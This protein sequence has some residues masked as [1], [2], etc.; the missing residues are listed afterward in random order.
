MW[1][2]DDFAEQLCIHPIHLSNTIKN[3]TGISACG[4]LQLEIAR[5]ARKLVANLSNP[6]QDI[7]FLLDFEPSQFTKWY[8]RVVGLTPK[9][10]RTQIK[11]GTTT[12]ILNTSLLE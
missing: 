4:I 2:I 1:D 11:R 6:I 10:F 12:Q 9:Q 7:A 8:K 3:H 5:V